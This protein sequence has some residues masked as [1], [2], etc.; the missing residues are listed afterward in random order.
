MAQVEIPGK[1]S[2]LSEQRT[3]MERVVPQRW[4]QI[5]CTRLSIDWG[6]AFSKPLLTPY[7][8]AVVL[9]E[10]EWQE[11]YPMDFYANQSLG[12]WTVNH[13]A[14]QREKAARKS[15]SGICDGK[16][17]QNQLRHEDSRVA[18]ETV[19]SQNGILDRQA[20]FRSGLS[21]RN[22]HQVR[23]EVAAGYPSKIQELVR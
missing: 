18:S 12:Q 17:L 3:L 21:A 11:T 10:V 2:I 5:A 14:N 6:K 23:A 13:P 15:K 9:K 16:R 19:R 20:S 1:P 8:A 4:V 7:E 22:T